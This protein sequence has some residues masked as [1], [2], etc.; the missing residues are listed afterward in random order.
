MD[1]LSS[2][3]KSVDVFRGFAV[4]LMVLANNPGN[5]ERNYVQLRHAPWSGLT[6]ADFGFPFFVIV[7]G[8]TI[9]IVMKKRLEANVGILSIILNIFK[10]SIMLILLGLILNGFPV[11]DFHSIRIPGVLQRLGIVYLF[12]AL[13]Y[14]VLKK[15]VK[16]DE[17]VLGSL[18]AISTIII[19]GY[20]FLL[21]P[22]GFA[23]EGNLVQRIDSYYLK[24]HLAYGTWDP[25]GIISTIPSIATGVFGCVMG[26]ILTYKSKN[27]YFKVLGM[28]IFAFVTFLGAFLFS[29]IMFFSK[30]IW[31]SS[32]VLI[33][34]A[35]AAASL[36]LL[37]LICDIFKKDNLFKPLVFLGSSPIFVYLVSEFIRKT[38]W[39][40]PIHDTQFK[41]P[42]LFCKWV[43]LK[44]ITPWA[45]N[46]LDSLYFS[47]LYLILWVWISSKIYAKEK[48]IKI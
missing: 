39:L 8:L 11:Y 9:P 31:T 26:C 5:T 28:G 10:R 7:M 14:I 43:T 46:W 41:D 47:I 2:R 23:V 21:K 27:E 16:K 20:Y 33:T 32:F 42:L 38:L 15:S 22:Y 24:G 44:F 3:I 30:M 35:V 17:Y 13:I 36:T 29:K 4:A 18:I 19:L 37:Y 25:E 6:F 34:V 40:I 12:S 1:I 48:F 45:G